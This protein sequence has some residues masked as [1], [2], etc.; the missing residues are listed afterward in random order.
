LAIKEE[1]VKKE[2]IK[3]EI[4]DLDIK[5]QDI[6]IQCQNGIYCINEINNKMS[7]SKGLMEYYNKDIDNKIKT[8]SR[9][10]VPSPIFIIYNNI[11]KEKEN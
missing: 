10:S 4:E 9:F 6:S 1:Q 8:S 5:K 3:K 11:K 2:R 7:Y